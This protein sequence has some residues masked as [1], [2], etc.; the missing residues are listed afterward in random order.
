M[1]TF[2]SD[3]RCIGGQRQVLHEKAGHYSAMMKVKPTLNTR[4]K[5][6]VHVSK[7]RPQSS[8]ANTKDQRSAAHDLWL[9]KLERDMEYAETRQTLMRCQKIGSDIGY[10]TKNPE[11]KKHKKSLAIN[12]VAK[13][14][15]YLE[16]EHIRN[17][18]AL[19]Y[20]M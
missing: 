14:N 16:R 4:Q 5:P 17:L 7:R 15:D 20:R 11:Y 9:K 3:T 8:A 2:K 12:R 19:G 1:A 13:R 18:E 6:F 10:L